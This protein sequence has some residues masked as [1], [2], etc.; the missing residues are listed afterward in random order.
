MFFPEY[1]P[2]TLVNYSELY[3]EQQIAIWLCIAGIAGFAI[4]LIFSSFLAKLIAFIV[5]MLYSGIYGI[6]R[7][8]IY[9]LVLHFFSSIY[10]ATLFFTLGMLFDFLQMVFVYIL[11]VQYASKNFGTQ[12]RGT[13]WKWA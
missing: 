9:L 2:Y 1:F 10:M 7:Y 8:V 6:A 3:I 5:T 12:K 11:Y 4:S 13:L